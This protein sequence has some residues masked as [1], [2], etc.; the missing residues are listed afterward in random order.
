M[1]KTLITAL[2]VLVMALTGCMNVKVSAPEGKVIPL[3]RKEKNETINATQQK[4]VFYAL[5]GLVPITN[6]STEDLLVN[7]EEGSKVVIE[8]QTTVKDFF[9]SL[10]GS[11]VTINC[12]T[13][14][15]E[16]QK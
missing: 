1:K 16:E 3:G 13:V 4:T 6:N 15:V 8:T 5:W 14:M 10:I 12:H 9:I 11:I 7:V 2:V